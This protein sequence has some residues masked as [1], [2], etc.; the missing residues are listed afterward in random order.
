M[1]RV[2]AMCSPRRGLIGDKKEAG[3]INAE[4]RGLVLVCVRLC[5]A[6][7]N[8]AVKGLSQSESVLIKAS[9]SADLAVTCCIPKLD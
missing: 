6:S 8:S 1:K 2:C 9:L 5:R 4:G 7:L 3:T